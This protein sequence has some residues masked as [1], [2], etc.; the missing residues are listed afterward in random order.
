MVPNFVVA[1]AESHSNRRSQPTLISELQK[2]VLVATEPAPPVLAPEPAVPLP[3]G[4][5]VPLPPELMPP[6]LPQASRPLARCQLAIRFGALRMT[7]SFALRRRSGLFEPW[8]A[9]GAGR[10][11]GQEAASN[12]GGRRCTRSKAAESSSA[13]SMSAVRFAVQHPEQTAASSAHRGGR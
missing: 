8:P 3:P 9:P 5:A 11:T 13:W 10:S 7:S 2:S 12:V 4:A 6:L 1:L